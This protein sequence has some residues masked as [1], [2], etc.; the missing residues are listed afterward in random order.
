MNRK[1]KD[2]VKNLLSDTSIFGHL[3]QE[4]GNSYERRTCARMQLH[5]RTNCKPNMTL[6]RHCVLAIFHQKHQ[7]PI[8][9]VFGQNDQ[10][11]DSAYHR[12]PEPEPDIESAL[13]DSLLVPLPHL[14]MLTAND[15]VCTQQHCLHSFV[16]PIKYR[17]NS[18]LQTQKKTIQP[19]LLNANKI[20]CGQQSEAWQRNK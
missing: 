10:F 12:R 20:V 18:E 14:Q 17:T 5:P 15:L 9:A 3:Y 6:G 2:R 4:N 7:C 16:F 1:F 11:S 13:Q 19:M 8:T